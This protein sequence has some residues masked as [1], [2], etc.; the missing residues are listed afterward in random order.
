MRIGVEVGGT[1]T[2]LVQYD[3][4][5]VSISKVPSV[6]QRPDEGVFAAL[7]AAGAE[8][9]AL[10]ELTHGSTVAVNAILERKG[11][12][13]GFIVTRGFRDILLLQRHDRLRIFDL[14]YRKPEPVVSRVDTL[15]VDERI[16]ADGAV[17]RAL[18]LDETRAALAAFVENGGY[19]AVA[20]CLLNA[21]RNPTHEFMLRDA[22][23]ALRPDLYVTCSAEV[24]REF[25]EYERASTTT[26]AAYVQPTVDR[27]LGR[28]EKRLAADGFDGRLSIMQSNGGRLP[29]DG[30]RDNALVTLFSGPSAGVVGAIRQVAS[31]RH[32]NLITLDVGGTSADVCLVTD[33]RPD[34][35]N[36]TSIDGLP[37]HVPVID[38]VTVGAGG[39]SILWADEGGMLRVG[40]DSAGA[41]P[42]PVCYGRGGERPTLTD[43]QL[44]RGALPQDALLAGRMPLAVA[45]ARG[46][47]EA[48]AGR[49]AMSAE[50]LGE[51]AVRIANANMISAIKAVSTERGK[52]PR[53][54]AL[55]AFGGAGPLHATELA[56]EL[57]IGTVIV[58]PYPG[59]LSAYGLLASDVHVSDARTLITPVDAE[60]GGTVRAVLAEL[61]EQAAG[62]LA[63]LGIAGDIERAFSLDM[64]FVGQAFEIRVPLDPAQL[65]DLSAAAL[66]A[67]F[68]DA[69]HRLYQHGREDRGKAIEIVAYRLETRRPQT[70]A[71]HLSLP[72]GSDAAPRAGR[73]FSADAWHDCTIV[74]RESLAGQPG[75]RGVCIVEDPTS[76]TLVGAG[77][78]VSV[79]DRDNM[80]LRKDA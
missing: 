76:T 13:L 36:E 74:P 27:Y 31:E 75:L 16:L 77:W 43:A 64:R 71:P 79:D 58:P 52:D 26:L 6:P 10:E 29:V 23:R 8:V 19:D 41:D 30:I 50:A 56:D 68:H 37:V 57:G 14:F 32:N 55:V 63:A 67:L 5:G 21:Y 35:I 53:D 40:P 48:L 9:G 22:L 39:G 73:V 3:G 54:Y 60:A 45:A 72:A 62:R 80:I 2:D 25:R 18:V 59:V 7:Q 70:H 17:E 65:P 42:G 38:I 34:M 66:R 61:T 12:R 49:F 4:T 51:S 47:V 15:E 11:A 24:G 33:G 78:Q 1:F 28:L 44:M 46:R 69:H 20:I